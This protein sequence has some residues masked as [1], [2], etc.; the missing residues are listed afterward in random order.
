MDSDSSRVEVS[1]VPS[2]RSLRARGQR[3]L[4]AGPLA[5]LIVAALLIWARRLENPQGVKISKL[6]VEV[7]GPQGASASKA[8]PYSRD[9]LLVPL[10]ASGIANQFV[11]FREL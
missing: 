5:F 6:R 7:S 10:V 1:A 2:H 9:N 8:L 3:G 11:V 4:P